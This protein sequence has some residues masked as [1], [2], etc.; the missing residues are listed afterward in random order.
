MRKASK[1][2]LTAL[3]ILISLS[4]YAQQTGSITGM[5]ASAIQKQ[6]LE[7]A[8][9][10]LLKAGDSS[11]VKIAITDHSGRYSFEKIGKGTYLLHLESVGFQ[12]QYTR[13][14]N[15]TETVTVL[16][17]PETFLSASQQELGGVV[18]S[19]R[20]P[21]I[22]N[23]IDKTVVNVDASPTNTGLSALEVLE[24]SPGV[25]V[26]N[27]GN[28]SLKGKQGVTILID[29]KPTYLGGQDLANYLKNMPSN[30]LD[31]IEIMTQP[32]AKY[33]ASGNSG[34]INI[35]TKKNRASGFNG[36]VSTS[37]IF[38]K[39]FKNTNSLNLNWHK[40]KINLYGNYGYSFWQGF[41]DIFIN[42]S[43]RADASVPY[44]RYSDQHTYGK[45][46]DRSNEF[47]AGVDFFANKT[48]TWGMAV[49][50]TLDNQSFT[51]NGTANIYDSLHQF[52]QYNNA[53]SQNKSPLTNLGFNLNYQKKLDDKG[54]E[55]SADADYL[56]Y[57]TPGRDYSNNYLYNSDNTA[58]EAPYLL[59]GLLPSD[60]EIYSLKSDYKKPLKHD[61]TFEAGIK[62]SYVKTDNNAEYTLYNNDLGKWEVDQN[63]SNHFIYKEN[64]NAAYLNLQKKI[65]KLSV[66]LGL[67][68]EQTIA[69]GNQV[70][71]NISFHKNYIQLF[72]TTY[73]SYQKNDNNTFGLSYGRRIERP[74]YSALNPFQFQ[75]DR[76]TYQQGNPDLQPQF[77]HN[78]ELSYNYKSQLN[79]TAN[80]TYT[81]DIIN[82]VLISSKQPGDSNYTTYQTSQNI[83]SN[84]NIGL[85]V[86]YSKQLNKWWMINAYGSVFTNHYKGV[87][88]GE[89]IDVSLPSVNFSLS[90]QF[91]FNKGWSA[92]FSGWYNGK[93]YV[94][95]AILAQPMGMFA[96]G[97]GKKILKGKG[98]LRLNI[99]DPFYLLSFRGSS[100]LSAGLTQIHSYWDNRRAILTFTYRFGKTSG[101]QVQHTSSAGDEES[102]VKTG[103]GQQ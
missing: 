38:A 29:G 46:Q 44:S 7:G 28:V 43:S 98:S 59:N 3:A 85:S 57:H 92:E 26:D 41:N 51:S 11:L 30:Q 5:V 95:S 22:E 96:L 4:G 23:K 21:L 34:V 64:I 24:K 60:I 74:D 67:R 8:T 18:V 10:S 53:E 33:D 1:R 84:V 52:V 55:I 2:I 19:A 35:I 83:A 70:T 6:P 93:N 99:R 90:S 31:Q 14:V 20:R 91:N 94:S 72:P 48:T 100:E 79:V 97:G 45:Y 76:Y 12:D 88:A 54:Q 77:S 80:Y 87:I 86:N 42:R 47:K 17:I 68:A 66:Q 81:K 50:G 101:P 9:I 15:I 56:F 102:R 58:S 69:D 75:L 82:D 73:F 39:Y 36:T 32:S 71:R 25:T 61:A 13:P 103:S 65:K 37:A 78:I 40:G 49:T 63:L 27:D 89:A 62:S 16:N